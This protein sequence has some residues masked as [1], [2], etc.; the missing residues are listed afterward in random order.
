LARDNQAQTTLQIVDLVHDPEGG[1]SW[2]RK[3]RRGKLNRTCRDG[4]GESGR[5]IADLGGRLLLQYAA[6]SLVSS[7]EGRLHR[8]VE[9]PA[10]SGHGRAVVAPLL[11]TQRCPSM[12]IPNRSHEE[13]F[14]KLRSVPVDKIAE[15]EDF[16][17][18]R[19]QRDAERRPATSITRLSEDAFHKV[20][21]NPDDAD[22]DR[23]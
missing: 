7:P 11:M 17:D 15:V 1:S 22:Y 16:V 13:L 14:E 5:K 9:R 10:L 2:L 8:R 6:M 3:W 21:D 12:S 23:L 20:W 4:G 19:R 18:F